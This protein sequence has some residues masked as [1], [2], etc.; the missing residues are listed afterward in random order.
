VKAQQ[1]QDEKISDL[2]RTIEDLYSFVVL[3][4][5]W[6][7]NHVLQDIVEQILKQTIECGFFIQDYSR[8]YFV[9]M[10][11]GDDLPSETLI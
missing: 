10:W 6:V 9:G 8:R 3:T 7:E 2:V 5:K 1:V 11:Q 4:D